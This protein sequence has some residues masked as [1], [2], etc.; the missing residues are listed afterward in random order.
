M[1]WKMWK[2]IFFHTFNDFLVL[3]YKDSCIS[4][5]SSSPML[6]LYALIIWGTPS[7]E[8]AEIAV[9]NRRSGRRL[10]DLLWAARRWSPFFM[11]WVVS[12][13][14]FASLIVAGSRR[15]DLIVR[16]RKVLWF[17][18]ALDN[19]MEVKKLSQKHDNLDQGEGFHA[20]N[21]WTLL[22]PHKNLMLLAETF[23]LNCTSSWWC[24]LWRSQQEPKTWYQI[25]SA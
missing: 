7:E 11:E 18:R 17:R 20:I 3:L 25:L 14:T 10:L 22:F 8:S 13:S 16:V 5:P 1:R 12:E 23:C 21:P 4:A 15:F 2:A 6:L 24:N 19:S 9:D